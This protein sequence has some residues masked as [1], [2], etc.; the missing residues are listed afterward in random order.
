MRIVVLGGY[1]N[2]GARVC[3][4]LA[5]KDVEV[6]AAGRDPERGHRAAGFDASIGKARVDLSDPGLAASLRSLSPHT[7]VHCAGPF[8]A[9]DY[10]AAVASIEAGAHYVDLADGR[11][12]VARFAQQVDPI[13]KAAERLAVS[14]ASTVPALSSA[15][16]DAVAPR[17]AAI[18]EIQ[19]YIAPAQRAPRGAATMQAVFSYAGKRFLWRKDGSWQAA[20]GWQELQRVRIDGLGTRWAAACD[21]PDLELFPARYPTVRTVQFRA[22]LEIGVQHFILAGVA[23]L[24]RWGFP[25]PLERWGPVLDG[26]AAWFDRFGTES[27]GML[28]SVTGERSDGKKC[29]IDWYLVAPDNH[30]P[31]IPCMPAILIADKLL[32]GKIERHGALPCM[33]LLTLDEFAPEFAR[34]GMQTHLMETEL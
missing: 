6:L 5:R 13:A 28:V 31:E 3:R 33:G 25:I 9:Q 15:V 27:G 30:G 14:G 19:T 22:A 29:R 21:I 18:E 8:Q 2:F 1:G 12:F 16:V 26:Y 34:W 17:F 11:S 23:Q 24:R 20:Y 32:R 10:R 7:V 4:A